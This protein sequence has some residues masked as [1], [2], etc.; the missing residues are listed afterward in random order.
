MRW[1][2]EVHCHLSQEEDASSS[3]DRL[4]HTKIKKKK[5]GGE[6]GRRERE[7]TA[8]RG[9]SMGKTHQ[10]ISGLTGQSERS[11]EKAAENGRAPY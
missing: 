8:K 2:A 7:K 5:E 6:K 10:S 11:Q 3:K 4:H 9:C 1:S